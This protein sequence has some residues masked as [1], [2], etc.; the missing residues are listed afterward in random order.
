L[1]PTDRSIIDVACGGALVNKTLKSVLRQ[2]V[3]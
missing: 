1:M 2:S 3:P